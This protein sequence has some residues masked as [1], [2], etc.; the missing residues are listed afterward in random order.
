MGTYLSQITAKIISYFSRLLPKRYNKIGED[1]PERA[2]SNFNFPDNDSVPTLQHKK[3]K[4][5]IVKKCSCKQDNLK[6]MCKQNF[7]EDMENFVNIRIVF[8]H[9]KRIK[10]LIY[11]INKT[12]SQTIASYA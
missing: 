11:W 12:G 9:K 3:S 5:I 10:V 6:I 1:D 4:K 2:F 8:T 7:G